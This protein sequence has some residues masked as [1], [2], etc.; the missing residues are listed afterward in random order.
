M[1][2]VD[3]D[4]GVWVVV[5]WVKSD[6]TNRVLCI[7]LRKEY[8]ECCIILEGLRGLVIDVCGASPRPLTNVATHH[9]GSQKKAKRRWCFCSTDIA[10]VSH[11]DKK[12]F[13]LHKLSRAL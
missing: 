5:T 13:I 7:G 1:Q 6:S 12:T 8:R 2:L 9:S 3:V 11:S 10:L 4:S